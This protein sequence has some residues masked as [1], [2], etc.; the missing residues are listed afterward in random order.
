[1][2][3]FNSLRRR[4]TL[5]GIPVYLVGGPVRDAALNVPAN[6][7]D[8]VLIGDAP[9]LAAELAEEL[10]G[11]VTI[12]S[13]FGTAT[14]EIEGDRVDVVTARKETYPHPGSLP[15]VSASD[16]EDDLARRDFS[17][18]AMAVPLVGDEPEVIDHHGGLKDLANKVVRTLH[19][20]SFADD[21][22]RMFR[23]V[24]Y[25]QRLG[26]QIDPATQADLKEA[27]KAGHVEAVSSDRLRHEF[28]K[29]F[30][31]RHAA[32]MLLRAIEL[33]VLAAVHPAL[34]DG[35]ALTRLNDKSGTGSNDYLAALV[36]SLSELDGGAVS[37]RLNLPTDWSRLVRD[38]IALQG[39]E[40]VLSAPSVRASTVYQ[41]LNGLDSNAIE[42]LVRLS[43]NPAVA[44]LLRQYLDEWRL[45]TPTLTGDDLLA[46]GVPS[47]V[48]IGEI[49]REL[50]SAKLDGLAGSVD[51]E[52][53]L[54]NQIITRG[55]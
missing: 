53:A 21:P 24:R 31:E 15:E 47:G 26:L 50:H 41:T 7:L 37:R 12:H 9:A 32:R 45:V 18:N 19:P 1:L 54:V 51:A 11:N 46:M 25:E 30:E 16:L 36:V 34:S 6:D 43:Q 44:A 38:T 27:I 49:L 33:G 10:G 17:I 42:A 3:V 20:A 35:Q 23:A 29:I 22:T 48:K 28:E 39:Y 40:A 14:V 2:A 8:F 52:R 55:S 13:R 5:D 4:A